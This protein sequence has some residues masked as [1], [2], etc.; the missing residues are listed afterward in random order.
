[1]SDKTPRNLLYNDTYRIPSARMGGHAYDGGSYFVT[2]CT[3]D[4][5]CHF[6]DIVAGADG[7]KKMIL[8]VIGQF[9]DEQIRNITTHCPYATVPL[10]V[11]MP[12]HV[13]LIMAIDG[14]MVPHP[15]RVINL[16]NANGT[17][18]TFHETSL[19]EM[20]S[21]NLGNACVSETFHETS[22]HDDAESNRGMH[23]V[24][25]MQ[26]WLSVV[27]RL[28]KSAV[29]KFSHENEI[30]FAWQTRFHD[31]VIRDREDMNRIA[32]YITCNVQ[33]WDEDCFNG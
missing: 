23:Y 9:A 12:N 2:I 7:E 24:T 25:R 16:L 6:G 21:N 18:E 5:E 27:I 28:F 1:M 4:R 31:H 30:P 11:V 32:D 15:K 17:V 33:H 10:W 20:S 8:S 13:H 3:K 22:L 14:G 26:S 29:T 19:C